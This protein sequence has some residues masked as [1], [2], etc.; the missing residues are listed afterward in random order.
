MTTD[1]FKQ[2]KDRT[3][4]LHIFELAGVGD[5]KTF[6][7]TLA[8]SETQTSF[9]WFHDLIIDDLPADVTSRDIV[10]IAM[11]EAFFEERMTTHCGVALYWLAMLPQVETADLRVAAAGAAGWSA[12]FSEFYRRDDAR[13]MA[14]N[15]FFV[16]CALVEREA[17]IDNIS[18]EMTD[19]ISKHSQLML[20][21]AAVARSRRTMELAIGDD[22]DLITRFSSLD[23]YVTAWKCSKEEFDLMLAVLVRDDELSSDFLLSLARAGN[24]E[25]L[26]H[27]RNFGHDIN[28][29][30]IVLA[31]ML[32]TYVRR[33][34]V[35]K[36]MTEWFWKNGVSAEMFPVD[37]LANLAYLTGKIF[38]ADVLA[39]CSVETAVELSEG[40]TCVSML[41]WPA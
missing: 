39:H 38:C 19:L 35:D 30:Y 33:T 31:V 9:H 24:F 27:M 10:D 25:P 28:I 23:H 18:E 4:R 41:D 37:E 5:T 15:A 1:S 22:M 40:V 16:C 2:I 12:S 8:S 7:E 20:Q 17:R 34:A 6:L 14:V 3:V 21:C 32:R 36:Q 29:L 13:D 26:V 11:E